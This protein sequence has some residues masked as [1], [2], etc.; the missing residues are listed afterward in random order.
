M[1]TF[2]N[3]KLTCF[4]FLNAVRNLYYFSIHILFFYMTLFDVKV[5]LFYSV[6]LHDNTFLLELYFSMQEA[7]DIIQM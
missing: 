1:S 5:N 3:I 2:S 7:D 4:I 6:A